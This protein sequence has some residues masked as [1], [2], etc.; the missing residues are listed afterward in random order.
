MFTDV[1][2]KTGKFW[3]NSIHLCHV[4]LQMTLICHKITVDLFLCNGVRTEVTN[5]PVTTTV[6]CRNDN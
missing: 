5:V 6:L 2:T 3:G 4:S 1:E